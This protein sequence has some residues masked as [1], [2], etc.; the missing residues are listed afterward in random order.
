MTMPNSISFP[1]VPSLTSSQSS[2]DDASA[3][4]L[5]HHRTAGDVCEL[6]YGASPPAWQA[7]ERLYDAHA[8]YENP[9][10]TA[11][12]KDTIS[13]VHALAHTLSQLDVPKPW[14]VLRALFRLSGDS[15]RWENTWF[16]GLSMWNEVN[17]ISECDTFDGHKRTMVEHTLHMLILPGLHSISPASSPSSSRV[18]TADSTKP[19]LLTDHTNAPS[20]Q[21]HHANLSFWPPSPFHLKLPIITRL[22]FNDAGKITHHRD[23]WDVKDL[24]GLVPGMTLVQWVSSRLAAQ[25]IR[26]IVSVGRALLRTPPQDEETGVRPESSSAGDAKRRAAHMR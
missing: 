3:L 1:T 17:N 2:L 10:L 6:F 23:F 22:S 11:T 8:T 7:V 26:G 14:A 12:S 20:P 24:L 5:A 19:L 16:R 25:S 18:P 9:F 13:D 21:L 15:A 4:S